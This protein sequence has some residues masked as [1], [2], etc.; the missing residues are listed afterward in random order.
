MFHNIT[1]TLKCERFSFP[2]AE[3]KIFNK[4]GKYH[5][6]CFAKE[7]SNEIQ[8]AGNSNYSYAVHIRSTYVIMRALSGNQEKL[9]TGKRWIGLGKNL[10]NAAPLCRRRSSRPRKS[11]ELFTGLRVGTGEH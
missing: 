8:K 2:V 5:A 1:K 4:E 10:W 7:L 9:N 6:L 3:T 11:G